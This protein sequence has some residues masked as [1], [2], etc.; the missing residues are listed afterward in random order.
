MNDDHP[1]GTVVMSQVQFH[2]KTKKE[3][4]FNVN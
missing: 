2:K 1:I 4:F 3:T